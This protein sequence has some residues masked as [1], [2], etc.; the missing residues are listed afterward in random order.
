MQISWA[1]FL[2]GI[3]TGRFEIEIANSGEPDTQTV[4]RDIVK[5]QNTFWEA[6]HS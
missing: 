1:M 6:V 4:A 5:M 3:H 2:I